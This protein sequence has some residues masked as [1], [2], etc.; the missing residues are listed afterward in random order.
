MLNVKKGYPESL[1]DKEIKEEIE[2]N[3][4]FANDGGYKPEIIIAANLIIQSGQTEL[5]NRISKRY[6]CITLVLTILT[7]IS[8]VISIYFGFYSNKSDSDWKKEEIELLKDINK[9]LIK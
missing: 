6:S 3:K 1:S 5:N 9:N 7:V 4:I 2:K 8:A